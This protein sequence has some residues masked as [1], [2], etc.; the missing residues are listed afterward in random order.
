MFLSG[1]L[2]SGMLPSG[3]L[4]SGMLPSGTDG[5][6]QGGA[7]A[8]A[9]FAPAAANRSVAPSRLPTPARPT[10]MELLSASGRAVLLADAAR[11]T[12][13]PG[14]ATAADAAPTVAFRTAVCGIVTR[15]NRSTLLLCH[16]KTVLPGGDPAVVVGE[17]VALEIIA[18][19]GREGVRFRVLAQG[20]PFHDIRHYASLTL[21]LP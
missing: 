2:P 8:L 13:P 16:P 6:W 20:Q 3:M 19:A 10:A 18:L 5:R 7:A 1:M 17:S 4:L 14:T 11:R 15:A 9:S 12:V 21:D